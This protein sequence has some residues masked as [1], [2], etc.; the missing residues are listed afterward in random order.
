MIT[1]ILIHIEKE[2]EK[3]MD[4]AFYIYFEE[5]T[6]FFIK[7]IQMSWAILSKIVTLPFTGFPYCGGV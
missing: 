3:I 5:L 7:F 6:N 1:K 2:E 4:L